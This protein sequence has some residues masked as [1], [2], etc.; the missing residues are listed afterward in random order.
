MQHF[1]FRIGDGDHFKTSSSKSIWGINS[2]RSTSKGF[3]RR[4][5]PGALLWFV[6]GGSGGQ[7]IA[8]ATFK[9][10]KT[11]QTGPLVAISPTDEELGWTKTKGYWDTEV[12]YT[13]LYNL[14]SCELYSEI[15]GAAVIRQYNEKCKVD[16]PNE[17]HSIVRYS[18]I[19]ECM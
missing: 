13:D 18:K 17:Y 3:L 6:T 15:K 9:Q 14:S 11:R 2:S 4:A 1:I 5:K 12:H 19:T 8:V 10:T 7:I 16:L